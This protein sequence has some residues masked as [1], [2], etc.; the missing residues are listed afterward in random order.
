MNTNTE[1]PEFLTCESRITFAM[2]MFTAGMM[3]A[4]T[5]V[6]RGGVFCNAQ[7]ANFVLMAVAFGKG[8]IPG[9]F[10]FFIPATAYFAGAFFSELL[11]NP[12]KRHGYLRWDTLLI[13]I[14]AITLFCVGFIPLS[15]PHQVTQVI[16]NFIASMQYNTFRQAEGIPMATTFCTNHLRQTGV[17]CAK[18]FHRKDKTALKRGKV[19]FTMILCFIC[20]GFILT[21][22]CRYL[23]EKA[24]WL[25]LVPLLI[26][27][28][29]LLRA[30]LIY[31]HDYLELKPRGH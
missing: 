22:A 29:R 23:A 3:G 20:G 19:H 9:G 26:M 30:D 11:P 16:I 7:T 6:M 12:V 14:E 1:E 18:A 13:G 15:V 10:Y 28:I 24:I 2:L 27:F 17:A 21:F 31:E 25:A 5:F 4:Y 8:D